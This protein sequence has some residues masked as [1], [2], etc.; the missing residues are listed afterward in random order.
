[1][2]KVE[3]PPK[4]QPPTYDGRDQKAQ[5]ATA[6]HKVEANPAKTARRATR[7]QRAKEALEA[8]NTR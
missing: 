3:N 2:I 4:Y 5:E 1:M 7:A 8:R 6:D